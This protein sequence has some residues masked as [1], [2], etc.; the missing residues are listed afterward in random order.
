MGLFRKERITLV[1]KHVAIILDGNGRWAQRRGL[2]R[3]A[4]HKA[5]IENI[6]RIAISAAKF[7]IKALS[8]FAFSTENWSRPQDEVDFLMTMPEQFEAKFGDEFADNDIKVVFSGRKTKLSAKNIEILERMI[9]E[10][11]DRKGMVLNICFDYS[12]KEELL[13]AFKSIAIDVK[14]GI[15]EPENIS[16]ALIDSRLYTKDLP[17]LDL[18]IR[19][20]GEIRLSNFLLWQAAYSELYFTK[21][22]WP[23]FSE[24][25][26]FK[27]IIAFSK[28]DRRYGGLKR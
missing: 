5:G 15:I 19:T 6:R 27:A 13:Q 12:S 8:I 22:H 2:P 10:S 20:S 4:G 7:G 11:Q 17:P 16:E 23:S 18:L 26:L 28:R 9:R 14:K 25:D 21:T 24:R 1:P 3:T